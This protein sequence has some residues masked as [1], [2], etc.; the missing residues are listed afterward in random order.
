MISK[1]ITLNVIFG[2]VNGI[3]DWYCVGSGFAGSVLG[4]C[5]DVPAAL[6]NGD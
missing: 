2:S 4:P 3:K 1:I 6:C 5:Q